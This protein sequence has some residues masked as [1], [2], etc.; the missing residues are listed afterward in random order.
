MEGQ[1]PNQLDYTCSLLE[2]TFLDKY[3]FV[4]ALDIIRKKNQWGRPD[5]NRRSRGPEPRIIPS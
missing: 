1:N 3:V 4:E 5:L 2:S